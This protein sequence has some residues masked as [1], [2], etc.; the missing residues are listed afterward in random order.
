MDFVVSESLT[1]TDLGCFDSGSDGLTLPITVELWQRNDGG[2]PNDPADDSGESIVVSSEFTP[3]EPGTL[4]EG[5]RF[6][7]LAPPVALEEG[8]YTIVAWGYGAGEPNGNDGNLG[9]FP[10][11]I[12]T[13]PAIEFVGSSRFGDPAANGQFPTSPDGGPVNRYG[14]G[15]FKFTTADS[16]SD[17]LPDAWEEQFGLDPNDP[18]DADDDTDAGGPDGLT[19][20]QEFE[21]GTDPTNGDTDDDGLND[22]DEVAG[23]GSRPPTNPRVA[24]SD[25]DELSDLV[26][27]NTGVF[28][29]EDDTGTNPILPDSDDDTFSDNM[30]VLAGTDPNDAAPPYPPQP[31][32]GF[33]AI[34]SDQTTGNQDFGGSLGS[35]FIVH[36]PIEI[37]QLGAFDDNLDG[38]GG[39]DLGVAIFQRNDAGT[40]LDPADDTGDG[41]VTQTTFS[42]GNPGVL[43]GSY[44]FK[45]VPPVSL[46]PGP[47]TIVGWG[48]GAGDSNGNDGNA[49]NWPVTTDDGG[50]LIE[51]VGVSRFGDA[52]APGGFPGTPDGGPPVRYGAGTF[53]YRAF[54]ETFQLELIGVGDDLV[55][56]WD[57]RAGRVYDI[58]WATDPSTD[59]MTWPVYLDRRN[60]VATPDTNFETIPR[61]GEERAFFAI[62]QKE[63]PPIYAEDFE[64]G[65]GGW[66]VGVDD[67][68]PGDTNWEFGSPA[69]PGPSAANSGVNCFGT[70]LTSSYETDADIW[71]RSPPIDLTAGAI[72]GASV[73]FFQFRDIEVTFDAGLVRV[74][75]AA[76][77]QPLGAD[78][79][80]V[81]EGTSPAWEQV[82]GDLPPEALGKSV[83]LE[84]RFTS[85]DFQQQ[86]GWYIDD[87]EV[88]VE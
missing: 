66:T 82:E 5:N 84:F 57:S 39:G 65:Q 68:L 7:P 33:L 3:A 67:A 40:P 19:N 58:L 32:S 48:Y 71:L 86:A 52:G 70:N 26:E 72:T 25:G 69:S 79:I 56:R 51:F 53:S 31:F 28:V 23:A 74:L 44:R 73:R 59:P 63:A 34:S 35:D 49:G 4:E 43:S 10:T 36:S 21:L 41:I 75:D 81:I 16:D 77:D 42:T 62:L 1:V 78:V 50:G 61:P 45:S 60:I 14:A 13:S 18:S 24:D 88:F 37:M 9:N 47:Y 54:E 64:S 85:D 2:T 17:G 11:T 87:V 20:L 83:K 12:A 38:I 22:G 27:S 46:D 30:E 80:S 55:L 8:A 76:T 15:T 6:M 29:D